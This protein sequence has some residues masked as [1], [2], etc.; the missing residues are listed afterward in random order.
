MKVSSEISEFSIVVTKHDNSVENRL[1]RLGMTS[2]FIS[3]SLLYSLD[4]RCHDNLN[5][6]QIESSP[7]WIF[8][9][10]ELHLT[11]QAN[12]SLIGGV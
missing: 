2:V 5:L 8:A 10:V 12:F 11:P 6:R 7:I 1:R 4:F 3:L 9:T